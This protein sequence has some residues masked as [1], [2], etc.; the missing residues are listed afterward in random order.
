MSNAGKERK[1]N[2]TVISETFSWSL[3]SCKSIR[4]CS[5][6]NHCDKR[7]N[8]E[9]NIDTNS[10]VSGLVVKHTSSVVHL[11]LDLNNANALLQYIL[12]KEAF[13]ANLH[14]S[15]YSDFRADKPFLTPAE[16]MVWAGWVFGITD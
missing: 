4:S 1:R 3:I 15:S 12:V 5:Y 16:G 2:K 14:W 10:C 9:A 6:E 8:E 7:L 13:R 11:N